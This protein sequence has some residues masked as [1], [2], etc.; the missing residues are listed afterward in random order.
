MFFF[1]E[2]A[3]VYGQPALAASINVRT[4]VKA[5][6]RKDN[7]LKINSQGVAHTEGRIKKVDGNYR[8]SSTQGL[9]K[10]NFVV[11]TVEKTLNYIDSANGLNIEI[12]SDIPLGSGLGSSSAVTTAVAAAV[13]SELDFP[14]KRKEISEIGY[15]T[16]LDVQGAASKTG[17]NVAA[18]GGFLKVREERLD[19]VENIPELNVLIGYTGI[20]GDTGE[21][22]RKVRKLRESRPDTINPI[23]MNIGDITE[24]G[25]E[26]LKGEDLLKVGVL[27]NANQN[28]LEALRVSSPELRSLIQ[29]SRNAGAYGA[30][31][32][33]GGDGG[34]MIALTDGNKRILNIIRQNGGD[35]IQTK[36]GVEGLKY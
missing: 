24:V 2:H 18:F 29:A 36:V 16:E 22:V 32:T 12:S 14:L 23:I 9:D 35:P 4:D 27:M 6:I 5:S 33:G 1:G 17:V 26:A 10:L 13:S 31:L 7:V 20:H 19:R 11:K 8:F 34:C 3:V 25:T 30:K 15:E 21:Q 28:L